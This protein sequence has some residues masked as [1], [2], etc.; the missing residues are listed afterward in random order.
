M[1][2]TVGLFYLI[3]IDGTPSIPKI[4]LTPLF[5]PNGFLPAR[6]INSNKQQLPELKTKKNET[7]QRFFPSNNSNL[8]YFDRGI[9][10]K[11]FRN[12]QFYQK[13]FHPSN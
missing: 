3:V 6:G 12:N 10:E 11:I 7:V 4:L 5:L 2:A 13:L 1:T 8:Y 9:Q